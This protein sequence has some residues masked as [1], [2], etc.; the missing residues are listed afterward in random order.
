M[1][2]NKKFTMDIDTL[3][4]QLDKFKDVIEGDSK[5][6]I[7]RITGFAERETLGNPAKRML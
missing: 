7:Y 1:S 5:Q 6:D 3:E 4:G 2:D